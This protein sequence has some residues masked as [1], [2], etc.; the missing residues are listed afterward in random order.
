MRSRRRD[1]PEAEKAA[2]HPIR[3][4]G[5]R[6]ANT[7]AA[8]SSGARP[9]DPRLADQPTEAVARW[10][11]GG[12]IPG[13]DFP[14]STGHSTLAQPGGPP[15]ERTLQD[16]GTTLRPFRPSGCKCALRIGAGGRV[17]SVGCEAG[18]TVL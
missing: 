17:D 10:P 4:P 13:A 11:G 15:A 8:T 16:S 5:S 14:R 18:S 2:A 7:E 3:R 6:S 12:G 9:T 1:E